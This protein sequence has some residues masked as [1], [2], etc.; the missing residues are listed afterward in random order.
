MEKYTKILF[1]TAVLTLAY[2]NSYAQGCVAIRQF[3]GVGTTT[4][5]VGGQLAGD[6][7][8]A[9]NYRYFKSFRHFSGKE[10][11]PHRVEQGT[12]VI[13]KSH[14]VDLAVN[15]SFT[16]RFFGSLILPFVTHDRSS[17]Y[18]HGGNPPN[19]L[20]E[21]HH[22]SVSGIADMRLSA[23]YWLI[24]PAKAQHGNVSM[25]LGIKLPTGAYGA[26]G[27]FYNQ[28]PD[29]NIDRIAVLDQSIQ[30]GDGGVGATLDVQG[31]YMLSHS[32]VLS[33]SLFYLA[34][35]KA[36]NGVLRRGGDAG[37]PEF[38]EFSVPDQ[39]A[40][41]IGATYMTPM[42]GISIYGGGRMECLTSTDLF[43]SSEGYRRPGYVIS[44]EPGLT[45]SKGN[46]AALV[47]VPLA[48]ERNRT[49]S[50]SDK[51]R[52]RHGDAAFADYMIN[53]GLAWR[54]PSKTSEVFNSL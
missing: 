44:V 30:P 15:Y 29:R 13:N 14:F 47:S 24:S 54:I 45:Y 3:S 10:E 22:T 34:N 50:F 49:K 41:R 11:H 27:M 32:V 42:P 40:V 35:P 46:F 12:E 21:R 20:G 2:I 26:E 39:Y 38:D 31:F 33:G 23:N 51:I 6:W 36:T 9:L 18:E 5:Q 28:G 19:G 1:A 43:G 37:T 4:G 17:M 53:V 52:D 16:D 48:V 7:N 8:L 25:G